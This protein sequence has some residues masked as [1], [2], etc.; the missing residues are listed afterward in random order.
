MKLWIVCC[1][2]WRWK[3][4]EVNIFPTFAWHPK[5]PL[6]EIVQVWICSSLNN[7][8]QGNH[9]HSSDTIQK[10]RWQHMLLYTGAPRSIWNQYWMKRTYWAP[11]HKIS[12]LK[13]P[14]TVS[15]AGNLKSAF[16]ALNCVKRTKTKVGSIVYTKVLNM[17][18]YF[19]PSVF[20]SFFIGQTDQERLD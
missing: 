16:C 13:K 11:M 20:F 10:L 12:H 9:G 1:L 15:F 17:F 7:W 4:V 3:I 6:S 5:I 18:V 2:W 8:I 19:L 14:P